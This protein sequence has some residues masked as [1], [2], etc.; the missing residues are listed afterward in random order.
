VDEFW[1]IGPESQWL[2]DYCRCFHHASTNLKRLEKR[3]S[4]LGQVI[5][6]PKEYGVMAVNQRLSACS[7]AG[8]GGPVTM[9]NNGRQRCDKC[10]QQFPPPGFYH[11][12]KEA[13]SR[14][15]WVPPPSAER[16]AWADSVLPP[17]PVGVTARN[18]R[19]YGRNLPPEYYARLI[20]RLEGMGYSP[21]WLGE[22][23]TTHPCP[24]KHVLDLRDRPEA[25]DLESVL[26]VVS[27]LKFTVQYWTAST[28]LAGVMGVPYVLFESP[29]QVYGNGQEG[30][31]LSLCTRGRRKVVLSHYR[32]VLEDQAGGL[33]LTERAIRELEAGDDSEIIGM[34]EDVETIRQMQQN[35]AKRVG[36]V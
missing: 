28:R 8:C 16:L 23:A 27:R 18:R 2:R 5:D 14:A 21:V 32:S 6:T 26:A 11:Y 4:A 15:V 20:E 22:A 34:V 17:N 7:I 1:E 25:A 36:G 3:A 12:I 24:V 29:D 31:R 19:C 33:D 30:Y 35:N 13:K 10:N 9:E